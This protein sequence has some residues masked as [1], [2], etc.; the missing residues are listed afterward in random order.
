[1]MQFE[2]NSG[3]SL[4]YKS[5]IVTAVEVSGVIYDCKSGNFMMI[6]FVTIEISIETT[7]IFRS[8]SMNSVN[9][10]RLHFHHANFLNVLVN[11]E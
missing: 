3:R 2:E 1:M 6:N 5:F 9:D 4:T 8:V 11:Q 10:Q 7:W